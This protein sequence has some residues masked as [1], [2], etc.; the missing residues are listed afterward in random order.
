MRV[1]H[2][3]GYPHRMAGANRSL[4][5]LVSN[6]PARVDAQ[7]LLTADAAVA[8]AYRRAGIAVSVLPVGPSLSLFGHALLRMSPAQKAWA[9]ARDLL[10]F[11]VRLGQF[12]RQHRIDVV[13]AN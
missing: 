6:Y 11:W 10:P 12:V 8:A 7:V 9:A 3:I 2:V 4:L 5:E 1:L 13:H